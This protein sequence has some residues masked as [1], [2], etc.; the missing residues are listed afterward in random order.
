MS[1][2]KLPQKRVFTDVKNVNTEFQPP[3]KLNKNSI[4]YQN[5]P[6]NSPRMQSPLHLRKENAPT[7]NFTYRSPIK[8][9]ENQSNAP[10][11]PNPVDIEQE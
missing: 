10:T 1:Y 4:S 9:V 2:T 11:Q 3:L 8:R 7:M 6:I 5:S